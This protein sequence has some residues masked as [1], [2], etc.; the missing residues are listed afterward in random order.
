MPTSQPSKVVVEA[1]SRA[2][3][4]CETQANN[5]EALQESGGRQLGSGLLKGFC[6][7]GSSGF[8]EGISYEISSKMLQ[9]WWLNMCV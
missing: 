7:E 5:R 9:A 2:E 3:L 6:L 1:A 4:F 8:E